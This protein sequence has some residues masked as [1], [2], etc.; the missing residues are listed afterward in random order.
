[1]PLRPFPYQLAIGTDIVHVNRIRSILL[2]AEDRPQHFDRFLR[3]FLTPVEQNDFVARYGRV[4]DVLKKRTDVVSRHLAGR[5]VHTAP[6]ARYCTLL[7]LDILPSSWSRSAT[8]YS[9]RWAAKEACIKAASWRR[10]TFHDV[11]IFPTE[12]GGG[13]RAVILDLIGNDGGVDQLTS[14]GSK[15]VGQ[16]NTRRYPSSATN[17]DEYLPMLSKHSPTKLDPRCPD[18]Q[19]IDA[20]PL[21][22]DPSSQHA[23]DHEIATGHSAP[24]HEQYSGLSG[25]I[26]RISI[27]H[28]GDYATAVCLAVQEP[29]DGDVGGE[30]DARQP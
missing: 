3:R 14:Q 29:S 15:S 28:D 11:V 4:S 12:N 1:M 30:A 25:Q 2:R 22:E 23:V 21:G 24:S 6:G 7:A 10:L 5:Y 18:E 17:Q 20:D 27:S 16:V 26:A 8:N 9:H 13:L 19:I